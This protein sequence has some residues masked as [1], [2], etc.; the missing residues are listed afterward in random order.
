[1]FKYFYSTVLIF[2]F[3][4]CIPSDVRGVA[5]EHFYHGYFT[6]V[7]V[8]VVNPSEHIII[9]VKASGK[10]VCRETV[11]ILAKRHGAIAAVNGGFWKLNGNPAGALKINQQWFGT[12]IKPRGA[13]GWSLVN[14]KVLIDRILTNYLLGECPFD[15]QIEAIPVSTSAHTTPEEWSECEHIVGGTPV[16]LHKGHVIKDFSQELTLKSF[17][18]KKHSRTAVGIKNNGDWV[19]VVVDSRFYGLFGGMSMKELSQLMLELGCIEA[20]NLDGGRSSTMFVEG[21]V[22]NDPHGKIYEE[23]KYVEAVSDAI[24][25]F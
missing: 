13:I 9:P 10:E 6:S 17:L 20:L 11:L 19:F 1:M 15:C 14:Q 16:L 12:P 22:V 25:I 21:T 18:I 24:L 5:Y 2:L 7:H 4:V 23:G 8:L 3:I